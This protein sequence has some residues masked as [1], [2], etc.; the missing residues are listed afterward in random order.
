MAR[1][2]ERK[3][4]K[5]EREKEREN[6]LRLRLKGCQETADVSLSHQKNE[7]IL[8]IVQISVTNK[9][10]IVIGR[11]DITISLSAELIILTAKDNCAVSR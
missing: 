8:R 1:D 11:H 3:R 9:S 5:G 6:N 10:S 2:R 7:K 4:E